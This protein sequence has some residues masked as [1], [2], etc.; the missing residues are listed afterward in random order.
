MEYFGDIKQTFAERL[1]GLREAAGLSQEELGER[2]GTSRGSISFYEKCKR[3]PDIE[4][5]SA[6][7]QYFDVN[8][9]FLL[10]HTENQLS[11]NEDIGLRFGLS[12]K[13]ISILEDM[14]LFDHSEFLSEIIEHES[15]PQLFKYMAMYDRG[16]DIH[17]HPLDI[18]IEE[19]E[20]RRFQITRIIMS[21]LTD[22]HKRHIW[23]GPIIK[24]ADGIS[25]DDYV[26]KMFLDYQKELDN[27]LEATARIK[28]QVKAEM[29]AMR[30]AEMERYNA[31]M[32]KFD[33]SPEEQEGR[34][35]RSTAREY[36]ESIKGG[37]TNGND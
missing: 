3:T 24:T 18:L 13:A 20:F 34:R 12:D 4:F 19:Y 27:D 6:V 37:G 1:K 25:T 16:F 32:A 22:L 35:V 23:G 36:V 14:E 10:G 8:A 15:F 17:S 2:L 33:N 26:H 9:N 21:I 7:C 29:D 30:A 28:A 5:L 31:R 11:A